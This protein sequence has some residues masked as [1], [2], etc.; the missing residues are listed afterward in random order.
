MFKLVL[1]LLLGAVVNVAVAWGCGIFAVRV[2][3]GAG[4]FVIWDVWELVHPTRQ[5]LQWL[6]RSGWQPRP[7]DEDFTWKAASREIIGFGLTR[8]GFFDYPTNK[9]GL[10][11]PMP[12]DPLFVIRDRTGWPFRCLQAE[13][14]L[15]NDSPVKQY[16]TR[17][18]VASVPV[19]YMYSVW[20]IT[21]TRP[22]AVLPIW[23]GFAIN[24][25][26]YA[27]LL[28]IVTLG[29]GTAR[30]TI[31]RK[32]GHCINCGYDLRGTSG[33]GGGVCPECG[34]ESL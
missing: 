4:R 5:D 18:A 21:D 33:G 30:R 25:I 13:K 23:P 15:V 2:P 14:W 7:E 16:Q 24:T 10:N 17:F 34:S 29:P 1:F 12:V 28:W 8:K 31:R 26:F 22:L 20:P 3:G 27:A 19:S 11:N 9:P 6:N 32:R